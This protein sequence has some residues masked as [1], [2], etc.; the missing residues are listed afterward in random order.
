MLTSDRELTEKDIL[1]L[2]SAKAVVGFLGTPGRKGQGAR[3]VG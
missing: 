2:S 1:G 3:L